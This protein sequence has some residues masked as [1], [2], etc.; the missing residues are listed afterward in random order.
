[1]VGEVLTAIPPARMATP[2]EAPIHCS[3]AAT[4]PQVSTLSKA[5]VSSSQGLARSQVSER[6]CPSSNKASASAISIRIR[7]WLTMFS[8]TTPRPSMPAHSPAAA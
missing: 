4:R 6:R 8:S 1:M 5:L 2:G 7:V 3:T